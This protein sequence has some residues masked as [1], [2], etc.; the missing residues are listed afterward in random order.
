M[1]YALRE[2]LMKTTLGSR[3]RLL[4]RSRGLSQ[5]VVV[6]LVGHSERWLRDV[7]T[8]AVDLWVTDAILLADALHVPVVDILG[9]N[10]DVRQATNGSRT[11]PIVLARQAHGDDIL[12]SIDASAWPDH[13]RLT[14]ALDGNDS[15]DARLIESLCSFAREIPGLWGK[16]PS[17]SFRRLA[18]AHLEALQA[19][20][21]HP[22]PSRF[23]RAIESAAASTAAVAGFISILVGRADDA[24][25]Y[26][27]LAARLGRE[28]GDA[29][30]EA[31]ALMFSSTLCSCACAPGPT[32][33]PPRA[34]ALLEG[35]H[36]CLGQ[37]RAPVARAWVLMTWAEELAASGRGPAADRLVDE[38]DRAV[39][40]AGAI[41][42]D[43]L[44][45]P[46]SANRHVA[47]RGTIAVLSG[48]PARA[49]PLLESALAVL[50]KEMPATRWRATAELGG[51][52][53]QQARSTMPARCSARRSL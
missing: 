3:I 2:R 46:W 48:R 32:V 29:E 44:C 20:M 31:L 27:D 22:M 38:A 34:L 43:G 14:A 12:R 39:A 8:G 28:A 52:Y 16:L 37:T 42:A 33:D 13:E 41:P 24:V 25:A 4:R 7:E 5:A 10:S 21:R 19:L 51:A 36:R 11:A 30:S 18:H 17:R 15:C 53:A 40:E 9:D 35:A 45:R 1:G 47:Y 23:R 50:P 26:L 6:H 49:I